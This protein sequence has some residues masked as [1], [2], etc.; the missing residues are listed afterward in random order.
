MVMA[1][2]PYWTSQWLF[3]N[4]YVTSLRLCPCSIQSM[5]LTQQILH[6][7]PWLWL[8]YT[9]KVCC[10]WSWTSSTV[11]DYICAYIDQWIRQAKLH[12]THYS[13][14]VWNEEFRRE[15][16]I[17]QMN[18]EYRKHRKIHE[19]VVVCCAV[20]LQLLYVCAAFSV[21][22]AYVVKMLKAFSKF[23]CVLFTC[24]FFFKLQCVRLSWTL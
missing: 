19:L 15:S 2:L 21:F 1:D 10:R 3:R 5:L 22:R 24:M 17:M 18:Y 7:H 14:L 13:V 8:I 23:A 4:L 11:S 6:K 20:Y 9:H 16:Y 12:K